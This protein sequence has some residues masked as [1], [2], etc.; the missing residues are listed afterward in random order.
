[1]D[2]DVDVGLP[3]VFDMVVSWKLSTSDL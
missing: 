2:L 1:L 3:V